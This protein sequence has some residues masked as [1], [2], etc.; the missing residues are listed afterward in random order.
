MKTENKTLLDNVELAFELAVDPGLGKV[1]R[2]QHLEQGF[3]LRLRLITLLTA[4]FDDGTPAVLAANVKIKEVNKLLRQKLK[5]IK[6]VANTVAALKNLVSILDD[7]FKLP[8][9]FL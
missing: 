2:K 1:E 4:E 3:A 7:L 9:A 8:F 5:D 6:N